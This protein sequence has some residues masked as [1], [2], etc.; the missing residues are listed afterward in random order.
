MARIEDYL[1]IRPDGVAQLNISVKA[2]QAQSL[3]DALEYL[4]IRG[5]LTK[6]KSELAV[7]AIVTYVMLLSTA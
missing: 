6:S 5:G 3:A 4:K 2:D 1:N 7:N